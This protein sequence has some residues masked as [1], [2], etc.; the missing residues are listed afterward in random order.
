MRGWPRQLLAMNAATAGAKLWQSPPGGTGVSEPVVTAD[1]RL[2]V[3][4]QD[5]LVAWSADGAE[6]WR[7]PGPRPRWFG[8]IGGPALAAD[9]VLYMVGQDAFYA[10]GTD[11]ALRWKTRTVTGDSAWFAG[12]SAIGPDGT[13]Y[14]SAGTHVYALFGSHPPDR[15]A[16][17]AMW[18]HDAHRTG[19]V[20]AN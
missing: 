16:P 14:T 3:Q 17:W 9:S 5:G 12:S 11:G 1:G 2:F 8:W 4:L 20:P 6:L 15:T 19:W 18:R 7:H 13:V 10:I